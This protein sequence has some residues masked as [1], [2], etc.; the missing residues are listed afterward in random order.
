MMMRNVGPVAESEPLAPVETARITRAVPRGIHFYIGVDLGQ[1]HDF[2][3]I[4]VVERIPAPLPHFLDLRSAPEVTF[5]L[6]HLERVALGTP[7]PK[8]VERVKALTTHAEMQGRCT[9]VFDAT[10]VGGPVSD[11]LRGAGM[12]CE[13]VGVTISGG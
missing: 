5:T 13:T 8:V 2:T 12:G 9:V 4:A 3:A 7:Y 10:G 6:R 1:R 11:L